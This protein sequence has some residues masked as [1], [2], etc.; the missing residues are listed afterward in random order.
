MLH[1]AAIWLLPLYIRHDEG[2]L[3]SLTVRLEPKPS[4]APLAE[5]LQS[6]TQKDNLGIT[7]VARQES[8]TEHPLDDVL[9]S[10]VIAPVA[11]N[12]QTEMQAENPVATEITKPE[13]SIAYSTPELT[14]SD[15]IHALPKHLQLAFAVYKG[16]DIIASGQIH[17][18]LDINGDRYS[19]K[20]SRESSGI[21][22]LIKRVETSQTSEGK[23]SESGLQ[24]E[25]FKEKKIGA[26]D[27]QQVEVTFDRAVQQVHFLH[28]EDIKLPEDAQDAL[29]FMYQFSQLSMHAEIIP[30]S[31]SDGAR[32]ASLRIEIGTVEEISTPIGKLRALH[33]RSMHE[34][35]EAYFEIWLGLDYRMLPIKFRQIDG[36]ANVTEEFVISDIRGTDK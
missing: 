5:N 30:L 10:P 15:S 24:P 21:T 29:S 12:L 16:S 34:K 19:L 8:S 26:A 14:Q 18:Q 22:D 23:I 35:G 25:I 27:N 6:E 1:A 32:L 4:L 33:L 17:Q 9:T 11:E 7:E 3:P 31:I 2:S 28:G 36:S 20:S 13:T